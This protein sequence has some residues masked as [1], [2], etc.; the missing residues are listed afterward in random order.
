MQA[1]GSKKSLIITI[2]FIILILILTALNVIT[3]TT[4]QDMR[5]HY[6]NLSSLYLNLKLNYSL[7]NNFY[8]ILKSNYNNLNNSY[9]NLKSNYSNLLQNYKNLKLQYTYLQS[10]YST[11]QGHYSSLTSYYKGLSQD[12]LN[13]YNLLLSYTFFPEAFS[14]TLNADTVNKVSPTVSF[15]TAGSTSTWSSI[16]KIF[17]YIIS[18]INYA[19]DVDVPY[20]SSHADVNI[21]GVNYVANFETATRRDYIQTPGLT[22]EIKQGD[23]EDQAILAYAMIKY[24]MKYINGTEYSLYIADMQFSGSTAGHVAVFLP[25]QGGQ[26]CIIDPAG[27]YLTKVNWGISSKPAQDELQAYSN[28]WSSNGDG[29]ITHITLY[30]VSITNGSYKIVADGDINQIITFLSK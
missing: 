18:N 10:N 12:V 13:F 2:I 28:Y 25:V 26:V 14:R 19:E 16:Q 8:S 5:Q 7:L 20:I 22:L 1:N 24:Y 3:Y 6:N 27:K 29:L 4:L 23:C 17:D 21:D 15:V 30:D 11:L 9:S